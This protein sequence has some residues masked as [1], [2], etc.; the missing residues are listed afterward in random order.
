MTIQDKTKEKEPGD[1]ITTTEAARITGYSCPYSF[2]RAA[3]RYGYP[4]IKLNP[5]NI[6]VSRSALEAFLKSRSIG[7]AAQ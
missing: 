7:E 3:R 5:R 6:R 2:L 4:I 1:L